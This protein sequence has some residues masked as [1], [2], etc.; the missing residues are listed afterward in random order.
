MAKDKAHSEGK[1]LRCLPMFANASAR[2]AVAEGEGEGGRKGWEGRGAKK[3]SLRRI[4]R[5][6]HDKWDQLE[7]VTTN[8]SAPSD[9][10]TKEK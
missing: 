1:R 4:E 8:A 6:R 7:N 10:I 2:A 5:S 3:E 9:Y